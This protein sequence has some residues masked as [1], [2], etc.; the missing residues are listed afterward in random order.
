MD[1]GGYQDAEIYEV[2]G[3]SY[4][5][6]HVDGH[7]R[8]AVYHPIVYFLQPRVQT[9]PSAASAEDFTYLPLHSLLEESADTIQGAA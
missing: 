3:V 1:D 7:H 2:E 9:V 8:F 4:V 5:S 6:A